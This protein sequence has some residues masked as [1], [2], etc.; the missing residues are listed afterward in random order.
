[1]SFFT[2]N[3]CQPVYR[4][5]DTSF[6]F[7][8]S[9][10][11]TPDI[12]LVGLKALFTLKSDRKADDSTAALIRDVVISADELDPDNPKIIVLAFIAAE[13]AG[14]PEGDYYYDLKVI[15]PS[16]NNATVIYVPY[17]EVKVIDDVTDRVS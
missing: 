3:D 1:M 17:T 15:D 4:G 6:E 2:N 11:I 8:L 9:D 10:A 16:D 14:V 7:D 13:M 12:A 5:V